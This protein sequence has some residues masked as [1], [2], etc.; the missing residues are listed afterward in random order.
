MATKRVGNKVV[1]NLTLGILFT[2]KDDTNSITISGRNSVV[3]PTEL[4]LPDSW[5]IPRNKKLTAWRQGEY[6]YKPGK[7][8]NI[9]LIDKSIP[10]EAIYIDCFVVE[11]FNPYENKSKILKYAA[12]TL[13]ADFLKCTNFK[14]PENKKYFGMIGEDGIVYQKKFISQDEKLIF[15]CED[16]K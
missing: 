1:R 9:S 4:T 2:F 13:V 7:A 14:V 6:D 8:I 12:G 15:Y 5:N 10:F 3:L 16:I 11:Y